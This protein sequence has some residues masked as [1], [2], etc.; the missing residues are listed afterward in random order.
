MSNFKPKNGSKSFVCEVSNNG[1]G[2]SL[3]CASTEDNHY[4]VETSHGP[5][6]E[7]KHCNEPYLITSHGKK[8]L[9]IKA[10]DCILK[11]ST[12]QPLYK[13]LYS[14][15]LKNNAKLVTD[16]GAM[17]ASTNQPAAYSSYLAEIQAAFPSITFGSPSPR[18]LIAESDGTVIID[19]SKSLATNTY[20]NWQAKAINENHNT[21][22]AVSSCQLF[23]EGASYETKY[24]S[25][26]HANQAYVAIRAGPFRD[27]FGT[28]R[29]SQDI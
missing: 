13:L 25:T 5:S 2:P 7:P 21:R 12:Y 9:D 26:V 20:A 22:A 24:S 14:T 15:L 23:T 8:S 19:S 16:L 10:P 18:L 27:N 6:H 3:V 28:F 4:A 17:I 29:Y 11:S 1:N